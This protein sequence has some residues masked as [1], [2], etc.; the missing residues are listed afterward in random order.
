VGVVVVLL[1]VIVTIALLPMALVVW[2][3]P[4]GVD[5][6][7]LFGV[8]CLAT[9]GHYTMTLA[10]KSTLM[11]VTQPVTFLQLVW[12]VM[13]GALVFDEALDPFVILGGMIILASVTFI[14]WR[15]ALL[16]RRSQIP[17]VLSPKFE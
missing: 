5:L 13:L 6:V 16:K 17:P 8:A 15:E 9:L 1:S 12:A 2:V 3:P 11:S 10:F 7:I 14:T 4:S